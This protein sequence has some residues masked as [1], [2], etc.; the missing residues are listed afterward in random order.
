M[1]ALMTLLPLAAGAQKIVRK[2]QIANDTISQKILDKDK[3]V[4]VDGDTVSM[5]IPERNFGRYDRGLFNYLFIPKGKWAFGLT[6]SYGEL[7]TDD[8]QVLS[9]LE[10]VDFKGK[11][12]SI[13]PSISYFFKNNQ[14]ISNL[15]IRAAKPISPIWRWTLTTISTSPSRM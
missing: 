2:N 6:A 8:I 9:I 5:I 3:L 1:A 15:T 10:N 12:Y 13:K 4:I 7:N 11:I 14:S